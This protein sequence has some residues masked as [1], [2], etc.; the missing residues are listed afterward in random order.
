MSDNLGV[1]ISIIAVTFT[2]T[3]FFLT[4]ARDKRDIFLKIHERQLDPDL[5]EGRRLLYKSF[6]GETEPDFK[7]M[8]DSHPDEYS[9][10][11]RSLAML[12][13]MGLYAENRYVSEKLVLEEWGQALADLAPKAR[14][15][16]EHR[17]ANRNKAWLHLSRLLDAASKEYPGQPSAPAQTL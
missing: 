11:N 2:A 3:T 6:E 17:S 10:I 5:Q 14:V 15:F 8:R 12:D 7:L 13:V 1:I 9:K 4:R 16:I